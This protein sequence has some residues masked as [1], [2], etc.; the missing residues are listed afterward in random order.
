MGKS[1]QGEGLAIAP[2]AS[3]H[4]PNKSMVE[5]RRSI[6]TPVSTHLKAASFVLGQK[7]YSRPWQEKPAFA[8]ILIGAISAMLVTRVTLGPIAIHDNLSVY[9]VWADQFTAELARGNVYPRW[10]PASYAGLGAPVFYYYPPLAFYLAAVFGLTGVSTY[11]S[12]IAAF[13]LAFA[14]SGIACWYWLRGRSS[15]P[16]L[17]ACLFMAA[18]YHVFDYVDRGALSECLAVALIPVLAIGLRRIAERRGGTAL[19][20]V[21]YAAMIGTHLPLALL[22]SVFLIAPYAILH[23][24]RVT[25][26]AMAIAL[27]IGLSAIYLLPA[28]VLAPYHDDSQ[29]YRAPFLLPGYWSVLSGNWDDPNYVRIFLI[30]G[31]IFATAALLAHY[32]RDGWAFY[33]MAIAVIAAGLVPFLWSFPLLQKVQFPYRAL[34]LAEFALA[35]AVGRLPGS[36]RLVLGLSALPLLVSASLLPGLGTPPSD[37][38]RLKSVHPDVREYLPKGVLETQ[39]HVLLKDVLATRVPPP[40]VD[41][42]VVEQR[43]YFP[44]W[45]CG[46]AEPRTQLLMHQ[47]DCSPRIIWTA[48]E[49]L[50][51]AISLLSGLILLGLIGWKRRRTQIAL[52]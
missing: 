26:F 40:H 7:A 43:F 15:H 6:G 36:G 11:S 38:N 34:P 2:V 8:F 52:E 4:E 21:A 24:R 16:L 47:P 19:T 23:R 50:G 20:S 37:L 48:T 3:R 22:T 30:T 25:S 1:S 39:P 35:T 17:A 33:A 13:A 9:W 18:P 49:K 29:L 14:A 44:A 42:M 12:L 27:G 41:G 28:L 51:A 32:R 46:R 5:H 10:L 31:A 45:S